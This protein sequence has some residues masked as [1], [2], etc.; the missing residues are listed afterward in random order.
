MTTLENQRTVLCSASSGSA[1]GIT[2]GR[3]PGSA[4]GKIKRVCA[5]CAA[6]SADLHSITAGTWD[7]G[8]YRLKP[9]LQATAQMPT[10]DR[11]F[12][13]CTAKALL[14]W[15]C[16]FRSCRRAPARP[17]TAMLPTNISAR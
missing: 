14:S 13:R 5:S 4:A 2:P 7:S 8:M 16:G 12:V 17:S 9:G 10:A 6:I 11:H 3:A 15:R 1:S